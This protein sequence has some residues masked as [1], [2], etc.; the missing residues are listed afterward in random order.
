MPLLFVVHW[1]TG[2]LPTKL[3][4]SGDKDELM[5]PQWIWELQ[6]WVEA[7]V[8]ICPA[9]RCTCSAT[10]R[11]K[12]GGESCKHVLLL[13]FLPSKETGCLCLE[14]RVSSMTR[15]GG[16]TDQGKKCIW[17]KKTL[18]TPLLVRQNMPEG[19][20]VKVSINAETSQ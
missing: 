15:S 4:V 12:V 6:G 3:K 1:F 18:K 8:D 20:L 5:K 19:K 17:E 13:L 10:C 11:D 7:S 16:K 9:P 14:T 2:S